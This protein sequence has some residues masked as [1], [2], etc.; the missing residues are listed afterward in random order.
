MDEP[1]VSISVTAYQHAQFLPAC[2]D[3]ILAQQVDFPYEVLLGED[4]STDGTR[5]TAIRYA[6]AHPDII[7]LFLHDRSTLMVINGRP[8]GR[9]N[10]L[11]NVKHARGRYLC[12]LDGDDRWID[13]HRLKIMVERMEREPQLG[14]CFHNAL[15]VYPDGRRI[16]YL[17]TWM[18]G[19]PLKETYG[20]E[21]LAAENFIPTSGVMWRFTPPMSTFPA[22]WSTAQAGDWMFNLY[23]A[24]Q[25]KIGFIDRIMS[26]RHVH[27]GGVISGT[28]LQY[29][30]EVNL[31]MLDTIDQ[32]TAQAYSERIEQ[33]RVEL[34]T[35][36]LKDALD[37]GLKQEALS[38]WKALAASKAYKDPARM[39]LRNMVLVHMPSLARFIHRIRS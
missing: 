39:R 23:F 20:M 35:M 31:R 6:A 9:Y 7:R 24:R 12:H 13:P 16:D 34:H 2:L 25:G 28:D 8:T 22:E 5:E 4:G 3:S 21:D 38:H 18:K 37:K 10:F 29:K 27:G 32:V 19:K 30:I 15:N 26:E 1:L 36:A 17:R 33:R 14:I 11:N